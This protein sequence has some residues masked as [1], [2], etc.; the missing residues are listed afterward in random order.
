M[1]NITLRPEIMTKQKLL[2]LQMIILSK[3]CNQVNMIL[4]SKNRII[5]L[6]ALIESIMMDKDN[7]AVIQVC[8]KTMMILVMTTMIPTASPSF[9]NQMILLNLLLDMIHESEEFQ[10]LQLHLN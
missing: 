1:M 10:P 3:E 2:Y 7:Q 5:A 6:E 8:L 9:S 4:W